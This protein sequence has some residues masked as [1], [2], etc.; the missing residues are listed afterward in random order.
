MLAPEGIDGASIGLGLTASADGEFVF[1][2]YNNNVT[3]DAGFLA[4]KVAL[5]AVVSTTAL[6]CTALHCTAL[7]FSPDNHHISSCILL[8]PPPK[9]IHQ[10]QHNSRWTSP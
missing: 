6:H 9:H 4:Y 8:K 1:I 3:G 2:S 7:I 10:H 5:P